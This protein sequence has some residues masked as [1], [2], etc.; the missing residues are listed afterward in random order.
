MP[1]S[2][3]D[4]RQVLDVLAQAQPDGQSL[5]SLYFPT[6][7]SATCCIVSKSQLP[8]PI[9]GALPTLSVKPLHITRRREV[10]SCGSGLRTLTLFTLV[11]FSG[12][13]PRHSF[14]P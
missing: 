13:L 3:V 12:F 4:F 1:P 8:C 6:A 11:I 5:I 9:G 10:S 7:A 2:S 14:P